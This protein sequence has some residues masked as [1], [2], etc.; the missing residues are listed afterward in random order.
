MKSLVSRSH[1]FSQVTQKQ[2]F[3]GMRFYHK[4]E[5]RVTSPELLRITLD[6]TVKVMWTVYLLESNKYSCE[7]IEYDMKKVDRVIKTIT[8]IKDRFETINI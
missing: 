1:Y 7:V 5:L 8:K 3:K 2:I 4:E 6:I